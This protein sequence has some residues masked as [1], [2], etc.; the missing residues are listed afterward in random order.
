[1]INS[2]SF[3]RL[4]TQRRL[5]RATWA[6]TAGKD[7]HCQMGN[8]K[9]TGDSTIDLSEELLSTYNVSLAPLYIN[10]GDK[11][12]QDG[13][14]VTP[15]DLYL[16]V[17]KTGLVPKTAAGSVEDYITFF[18]ALRQDY[19]TV[20]HFNISAEFS[21][22]HQNACIAAQEV[23]GVIPIDSRNL[24]TGSG[25]L[26]LEACEMAQAGCSA[27]EITRAI[28]ELIPKVEASFILSRL[29]YLHKGG[30]CSGIAAM[31]ANLLKLRPVILVQDGRMQ[32]GRKFRGSYDSCMAD[33]IRM[34][35]AGRTDIRQNRIFITHTKCSPETLAC[36]HRTVRECLSFD[37]IL[38]TTAGCTIT[39]HCG[40]ETLGVLF[41]RR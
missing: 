1:M 19:E 4:F 30:R 12:Y 31:G 23:G 32:V 2:P 14:D 27:E 41:I 22:T 11:S 35:L 16:Y 20:I 7:G 8:I 13:V 6:R 21:S 15:E 18:R 17:A 10:M 9:I 39:N 33:Y 40:E 26:V 3:Q 37:E 34:K 24:S 29:D 25:L 36:A 38:E 5:L 28:Q